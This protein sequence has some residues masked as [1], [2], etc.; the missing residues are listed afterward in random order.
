MRKLTLAIVGLVALVAT[1]VAV[2]HGIEGA[3]TAK[4]VAGTFSAAAGTVSSR[5]CT[6]TDNKTIVITDGKYTGTAT[7]DADLT[8]AITLRA[9]SVVNST[10]KVGTVS[11]SFRIDATGK[12]TDGAF[13]AVYSNGAVSG[14]AAGRSFIGRFSAFLV[15]FGVWD[16]TYYLFLKLLIDWP[17]SVSRPAGRSSGGS[18]HSSSVSGSGT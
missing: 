7:G 9:R 3:K 14:L 10:D 4:T 1:S 5:T 18:R 8:G 2:A 17:A 16:L 6:T 11:G 13:S 15:G 12:D